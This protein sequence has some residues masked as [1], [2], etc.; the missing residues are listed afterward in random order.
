MVEMREEGEGEGEGLI[1]YLVLSDCM[2]HNIPLLG[3]QS[4][5]CHRREPHASTI[6]IGCLGRRE[7]G[8]SSPHMN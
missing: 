2:R 3:L 8:M 1:T 4:T 7:G 6:I 5:I